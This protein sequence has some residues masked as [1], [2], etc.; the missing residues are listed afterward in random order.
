MKNRKES[1]KKYEKKTGRKFISTA[2]GTKEES[3]KFRAVCLRL[4]L[5]QRCVLN[6][7][8]DQ[9]LALLDLQDDIK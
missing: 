1:D 7:I 8:S 5:T 2:R 6:M 9:S 3:D 4:K